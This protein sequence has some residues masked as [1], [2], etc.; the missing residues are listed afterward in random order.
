MLNIYDEVKN[1]GI[2]FDNH[3]SDLYIPVNEQTQELVNN[4]QYKNSV[5]AFISNID[6]KLWYDIPF[7]YYPYYDIPVRKI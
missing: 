3:C 6:Q 7:A 1:Q 5:T 2:E 4:Y